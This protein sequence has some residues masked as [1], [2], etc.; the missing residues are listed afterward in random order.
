[1]AEDVGVGDDGMADAVESLH[2]TDVSGELAPTRMERKGSRSSCS[3]TSWEAGPTAGT[4][5]MLQT[6]ATTEGLGRTRTA[7][8]SPPWASLKPAITGTRAK[9][10]AYSTATRALPSAWRGN[11]GG[12]CTKP[13]VQHKGKGFEI[14]PF[15]IIALGLQPLDVCAQVPDFREALRGLVAIIL[16]I[17][18]ED[19]GFDAKY[20]GNFNAEHFYART[21]DCLPLL[22]I[23]ERTV[24]DSLSD[25]NPREIRT[26]PRM[27]QN[28]S[29]AHS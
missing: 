10:G 27:V 11:I 7:C 2:T 20:L 5:L 25:R 14:L 1:M 3:E 8:R 26:T 4:R 18:N 13:Y 6:R 12:R 29:T 15:Q 17:A 24:F 28:S 23:I 19:Q 21:R 9:V 16:Q 22:E